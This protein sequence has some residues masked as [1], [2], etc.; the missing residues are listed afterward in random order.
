MEDGG[1]TSQLMD[2]IWIKGHFALV[3]IYCL[4]SAVHIYTVI[5]QIVV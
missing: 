5:V 1:G 2:L 4:Y 3:W